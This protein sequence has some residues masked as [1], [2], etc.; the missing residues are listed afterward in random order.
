M[1]DAVVVEPVSTPL[2]P[3]IPRL[4]DNPKIGRWY[5]AE[6]VVDSVPEMVPFF[7]DC[8]VEEGEDRRAELVEGFVVSIVGCVLMHEA[9]ASLDRIEVRTI[10]RDEVQHALASL[11]LEPVTHAP[12]MMVAGIV[13]VDMDPSFLGMCI[14]DRLEQGDQASCI[15]RRHYKTCCA[16]AQIIPKPSCRSEIYPEIGEVNVEDPNLNGWRSRSK[17]QKNC[18]SKEHGDSFGGVVGFLISTFLPLNA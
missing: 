9:P 11:S 10:G 16:A 15:V 2:F 6:V 18:S 1:A 4:S 17:C 14:F 5:D 12:G 13:Q 3:A 7:G 8:L